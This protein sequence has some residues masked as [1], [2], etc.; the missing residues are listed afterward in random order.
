[1]RREVATKTKEVAPMPPI[2]IA[3]DVYWVGVNDRTTDLFEGLW[4][5]SEQGVSYNSYLVNDEKKAIID[6]VKG[7]KTDEFLAQVAHLTNIS[8]LDYIIVNH[9]E[10]DHTSILRSMTRM[11][12]N[13][14]IVGS[15]KTKE[16]VKSFYDI[17]DNVVAVE[18][19][20]TISLGERTLQFFSTPFVHW[21]ETMMTYEQSHRILFSCDGF[22]GYGAL[23]GAIFDDA[24]TDHNFYE[25]EAL[26]YYANIVARFSKAVL[27]AIDKLSDLSVDIIA[28]SHGLIWREN[29]EVIVDLYRK[30]AGYATGET[31][32]SITLLYGTMYGNTEAL[33]NAVAQGVS[34]AG[35]QFDIF[36][37]AR[38][39]V[40]YILPSLWTRA[41]VLVGAPTYEGHLFPAVAQALE[42]AGEKGV[43]NKKAAMFGSY[44]W[45][46]GAL[47]HLKRIVEPLDWEILGSLEFIGAPSQEELGQA[48]EFGYSFAEAIAAK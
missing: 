33:M 26:R 24:C 38:T 9:M 4:P 5:I 42:I 13:A 22:G 41:G 23:R 30:W 46:G 32:P 12:P 39:H 21:P 2:E 15:A 28:P 7:F 8:E 3:H 43:K 14:K 29:P 18:D 31:E 40:S 6:L 37:A 1:M 10:Q 25:G 19:G 34:A 20:D 48:F 27:R 35:V 11:A 17:T 36:D 44:G 16:M 45:S 47:K